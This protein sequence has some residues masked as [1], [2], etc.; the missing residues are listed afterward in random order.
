MAIRILNMVR[1]RTIA[2]SSAMLATKSDASAGCA[3]HSPYDSFVVSGETIF[4]RIGNSS[5]RVGALPP[6][7]ARTG[8]RETLFLRDKYAKQSR[9]VSAFG[10]FDLL[11]YE[12]QHARLKYTAND[13]IVI[14]HLTYDLSYTFESAPPITDSSLAGGMSAHKIAVTIEIK[15]KAS[16][17]RTSEESTAALFESVSKG[18]SRTK[19][20]TLS[21]FAPTVIWPR[22][23]DLGALQKPV[24]LEYSVTFGATSTL[25]ADGCDLQ[26]REVTVE[27]E[28]GSK[29]NVKIVVNW[30]APL[31]AVNQPLT[32]IRKDS[33]DP[34]TL[35]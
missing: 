3:D 23:Y 35:Q 30:R 16:T 5:V 17:P 29:E 18:V 2:A 34:S 31:A 21:S 25:P 6:N 8:I 10:L 1:L 13:R 4:E 22:Q 11:P 20:T 28:R 14:E 19:A 12:P 9:V 7:L 33:L 32:F 26:V 15:E 27:D 24:K